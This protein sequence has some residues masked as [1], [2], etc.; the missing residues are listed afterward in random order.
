MIYNKYNYQGG[1]TMDKQKYDIQNILNFNI[2]PCDDTLPDQGQYKKLELNASQKSNLDMF[3]GE[4][5]NLVASGALSNAYVVTFPDGIQHALTPLKQGGFM[6]IYKDAEG[7]FAG[8]APLQE[9]GGS[10]AAVT[11]AFSVMSIATGQ[12]FLTEINKELNLI[13]Y[14]I[15]RIIDFLYGDKKAELISEINFSMECYKNYNSIMEHD[16][17]RI[18]TISSLQETKKV[19]IKDIEFYMS[20]LDKAVNSSP[21]EYKKF[22]ENARNSFKIKSNL[23]LSM[24]LYV[25]SAIL[26]THF[27]QN[28]D[29]EYINSLKENTTRYIDLCEKRILGD[30]GKLN[31]QNANFKSTPLQKIDTSQLNEKLEDVIDSLS[32]GGESNIRKALRE[33]LSPFTEKQEYRIINDELYL[34]VD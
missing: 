30:F 3:V 6:N 16:Y 17:Q 18:A 8:V 21:K 32:N 28:Y 34:K 29:P 19:A 13:N 33:A 22:Q 24:Q 27:S 4:I 10:I 26:E 11:G 9:I 12:Y 1:T 20:D 7:H 14:K 31:G 2:Q 25:L 5:P 23:E 15:D